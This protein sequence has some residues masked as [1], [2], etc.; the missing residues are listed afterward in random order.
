VGEKI[1]ENEL[2]ALREQRVLKSWRLRNRRQFVFGLFGAISMPRK[3]P[4]G[5]IPANISSP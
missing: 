5:K 3:T 2:A 1:E 4:T